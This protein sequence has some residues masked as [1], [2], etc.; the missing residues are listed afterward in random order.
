MNY[1]QLPRV[2]F[3][4]VDTYRRAF[5]AMPGNKSN[6]F[7]NNRSAL[8]YRFEGKWLTKDIPVH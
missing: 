1:N 6:V 3:S 4:I 7:I 2:T 5:S 8:R